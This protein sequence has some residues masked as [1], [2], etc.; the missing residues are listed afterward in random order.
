MRRPVTILVVL[1]CA[2]APSVLAAES[3]QG[4]TVGLNLGYQS[5]G[6]WDVYEYDH[7]GGTTGLGLSWAASLFPG[8][9]YDLHLY[10]YAAL[11]DLVLLSEEMLADSSQ[12]TFAP[13]VESIAYPAPAGRYYVAVMPWQTQGEVYTLTAASGVLRFATTAPGVC[14]R[15]Y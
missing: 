13:H 9:D 14:E 8:A 3:E 7:P 4:A 6:L 2:I 10:P 11:D 5:V 15:C 1:A 12:R